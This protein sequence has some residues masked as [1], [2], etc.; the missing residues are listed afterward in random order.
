MTRLLHTLKQYCG[1]AGFQKDNTL[2]QN[3]QCLK[4]FDLVE[5][6]QVLSDHAV[7]VYTVS[8]SLEVSWDCI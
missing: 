4:N 5:Y 8:S 3:E 6:R 1:D 2:K 7:W